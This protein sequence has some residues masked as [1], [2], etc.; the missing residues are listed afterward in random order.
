[1]FAIFI[2]EIITAFRDPHKA[3]SF[4]IYK[5]KE[6]LLYDRR[7]EILREPKVKSGVPQNSIIHDHIKGELKNNGFKVVDFDIDISE[8]K[9]FVIDAQYKKF[10]SY[11]GGG[12]ASNFAEKSLEHY[13]AAKFLNLSKDDIYIDVASANSPAPEIYHTLYGCDIYKQDLIYPMGLNLNVMGGDAS[14]MPVGGDFATKMALHCSFEHFE[15]DSD[16][17][18]IREA[19]RV[20]K[21]KGKLCIIPLYLFNKYAIQT[22]LAVLP[23][24]NVSFESDATLYCV[25][26]W[27]NRHGRFYDVAHLKERIRNNLNELKLTVYFVKNEKGWILRAT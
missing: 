21:K 15:G 12:Q 10:L 17:K 20:L 13:L 16:I 22:D 7:Y 8:Y 25:K 9:K 1:M 26:G 27:G 24:G 19:N 23:G 14:N 4:V 3:W 11:Y 2:S 18:F 5:I 6:I